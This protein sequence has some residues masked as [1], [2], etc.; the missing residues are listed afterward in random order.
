MNGCFFKKDEIILS[1][2]RQNYLIVDTEK[3]KIKYIGSSFLNDHKTFQNIRI[4]KDSNHL[5]MFSENKISLIDDKNIYSGSLLSNQ[6]LVDV[7]FGNKY[8]IFAVSNDV[9]Y[10][11]DIRMWKLIKT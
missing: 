7:Q 11:W 4:N 5:L 2:L 6:H 10:Q 8:D 3:W 1:T 9:F